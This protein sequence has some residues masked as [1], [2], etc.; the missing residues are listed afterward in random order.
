MAS[1]VFR[2]KAEP[3]GIAAATFRLQAADFPHDSRSFRL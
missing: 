1:D 3:T 2:L